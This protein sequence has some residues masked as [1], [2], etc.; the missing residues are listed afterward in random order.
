MIIIVLLYLI[1]K[2]ALNCIRLTLIS[3]E[4]L[5]PTY[6]VPYGLL[7]RQYNNY[8][9][10]T[11]SFL[12]A[13]TKLRTATISSVMSVR[14]QGRTRLQMDGF[15][16]NLIFEYFSKICQENSSFINIWNKIK[17]YFTWTTTYIYDSISLNFSWNEKYFGRK[18][19]RESKHTFCVQ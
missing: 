16:S 6:F 7:F 18:L 11:H 4:L 19:Y 10:L 13:F 9:K 15:T 8:I 5:T 1:S 14:R 3:K 12:G 17:G 2:N